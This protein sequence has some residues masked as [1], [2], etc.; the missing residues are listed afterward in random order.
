QVLGTLTEGEISPELIKGRLKIPGQKG[1][2][3]V[4]KLIDADVKFKLDRKGLTGDGQIALY[5]LVKISMDLALE[6]NG[7]GTF[8]AKSNFPLLGV[9]ASASVTATSARGFRQLDV[10][11]VLSVNMD[12]GVLQTDVSVRVSASTARRPPVVVQARALGA[13]ARLELDDLGQ[14]TL[15]RL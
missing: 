4:D 6:F 14:L 15:Q 10:D 13:E 11:A 5:Q 3:P 1:V 12:L 2:L 9:D 7:R 8:R